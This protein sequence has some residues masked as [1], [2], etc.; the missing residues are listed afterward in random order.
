MRLEVFTGF[1]KRLVK[2]LNRSRIEYMFTGALAASYYGRPRTTLDIDIVITARR[3]D[4]APL[5]KWLAHAG[6]KVRQ[7]ELE[8]AWRSDCRIVTLQDTKSPHTLD[9]MFSDR[10]LNRIIGRIS[11]LPTYYETAESLILAKLR[12]LKVTLQPERAA[13]DR[14]D[15]KAILETNSIDLRS[16]RRKAKAQRTSKILDDLIT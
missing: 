7:R 15:I 12:R 14:A 4:L 8:S 5:K 2:A 16:L 1:V 10:K 13:I 3:S 11:G 9:I 6:L